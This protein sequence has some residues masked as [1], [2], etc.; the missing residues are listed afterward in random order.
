MFSAA[1]IQKIKKA[2]KMKEKLMISAYH[3]AKQYNFFNKSFILILII[4]KAVIEENSKKISKEK[5]SETSNG[6]FELVSAL[7]SSQSENIIIKFFSVI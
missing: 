2:E 1:H 6:L 3:L 7:S 4:K 5:I